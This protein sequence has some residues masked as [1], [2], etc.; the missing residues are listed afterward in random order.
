M[1]VAIENKLVVIHELYGFRLLLM[2]RNNGV[3]GLKNL[4]HSLD[5]PYHFITFLL[6]FRL[7]TDK[8]DR[9]NCG[10]LEQLN[11]K[12]TIPTSSK[13]TKTMD[14]LTR[15]V[16]SE[17]LLSV[18]LEFVADNDVECFQKSMT[19]SDVSLVCEVGL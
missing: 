13:E 2:G 15:V 7:F 10:N 3:V 11:T 8:L 6:K 14:C 9:S 4:D 5:E 12:T 1:R 16:G 18:L 19:I 17:H